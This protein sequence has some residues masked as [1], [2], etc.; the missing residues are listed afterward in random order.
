MTSTEPLPVCLLS[1]HTPD[2]RDLAIHLMQEPDAPA[3]IAV[4]VGGRTETFTPS[5]REIRKFARR[6]LNAVGLE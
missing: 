3:R 6:L 2:G 5:E 4:S 1:T